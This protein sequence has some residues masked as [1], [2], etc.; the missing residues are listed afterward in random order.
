M[1]DLVD[2]CRIEGRIKLNDKNIFDKDVDV[3]TLRR[4]VGDG[5]SKANTVPKINL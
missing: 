1:N 5:I 2:S 3:A 4:N